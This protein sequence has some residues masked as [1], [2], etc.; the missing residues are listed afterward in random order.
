MRFMPRSLRLVVPGHPHH[1]THRGNNKQRTFFSE[2]DYRLYKKYLAVACADTGT[3]VWAWCLMP[4]HVHLVLVPSAEDGL[5][6]VLRR[7]QGRYTRAINAREGRVGHLWQA[8]YGSFVM[9]EPYLLACARYVELNP[10]RAGLAARPEDWPW[11]S[12]RAHLGESEDGLTDPLPLLERWPEWR[13][14]ID[15]PL[16]E[17]T[18]QAI[19]QRERTGRPLGGKAFVDRFG[20][21]ASPTGAR[22]GRPPKSRT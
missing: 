20:R 10:V 6:A 17:G 21:T 14:V 1:V 2:S 15:A 8:R 7:T 4:N 19:R 16:D 13:A 12:A 18:R 22:R 5:G 11:S 9:D 3:A